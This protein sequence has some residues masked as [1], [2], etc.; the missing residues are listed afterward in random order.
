MYQLDIFFAFFRPLKLD[1]RGLFFFFCGYV[2]CSD[3]LHLLVIF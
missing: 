3:K 2:L 1:A